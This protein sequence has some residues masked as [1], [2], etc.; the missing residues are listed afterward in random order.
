MVTEFGRLSCRFD[1]DLTQKTLAQELT[2]EEQQ[3]VRLLD[4][5][6][7]HL[8]E[9]S[10]NDYLSSWSPEKGLKEK[11]EKSFVIRRVFLYRIVW[12]TFK[13]LARTI[14]ATSPFFTARSRSSRIPTKNSVS[15]VPFRESRYY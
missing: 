14:T 6:S 5:T 8:F 7:G 15:R 12:N 10:G 2:S 3:N 11:M 1:N 4:L 13:K 9:Q